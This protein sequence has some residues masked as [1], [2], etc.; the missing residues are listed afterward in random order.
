MKKLFYSLTLAALL[1]GCTDDEFYPHCDAIADQYWELRDPFDAYVEEWEQL[2]DQEKED[3]PIL[4]W[5]L[6]DPQARLLKL[7]IFNAEHAD[8][9]PFLDRPEVMPRN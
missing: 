2:S 3:T 5:H 4:V 9:C 8:R 1:F 6:Q 7:S